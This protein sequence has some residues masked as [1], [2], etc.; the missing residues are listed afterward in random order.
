MLRQIEDQ[1]LCLEVRDGQ[2][3][4]LVLDDPN[5]GEGPTHFELALD[6]VQS[7]AFIGGLP[8]RVQQRAARIIDHHAS[9]LN[10]RSAEITQ[11]AAAADDMLGRAS[12]LAAFT[13][14]AGT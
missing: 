6:Q 11:A 4:L 8:K 13:K 14:R 7:R 2:L 1:V 12:E 3:V 9:T 5:E 10:E